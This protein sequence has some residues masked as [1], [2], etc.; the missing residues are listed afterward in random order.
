MT[1]QRAAILLVLAPL[2]LA[3]CGGGGPVALSPAPDAPGADDAGG[4]EVGPMLIRP[5]ATAGFHALPL[6][7]QGECTFV[8]LFGSQIEFMAAQALLDR[9]VF[10]YG[11]ASP[12]IWV[13]NLDGSNRVQLTNNAATERAPSWS[14][15]GTRIAF[16]RQWSGGDWELITMAANGSGIQAVTN[17]DKHDAHPSWSPDGR[18]LVY[19]SNVPGNYEIMRCYE[20]GGS[21]INLTNHPSGDYRPDWSHQA[22]DP[23]ILFRSNRDSGSGE[24]YR[25]EDD[26][27]GVT[28]LT[29]NANFDDH[30]C[31]DAG[32]NSIAWNGTT[33]AG[34]YEILRSSIHAITPLNFTNHPAQ[35]LRPAW[36]TDNRFIAYASGR[37]GNTEIW[38]QE[39]MHPWRAYQ[40]TSRPAISTEPHLG[41]PTMQTERVLI[42]PPGSDWGG[43]DPVWSSAPAGVLVFTNEGYHNFVRIGVSPAYASSIRISTLVS[44]AQSG[45]GLAGVLVEAT[46]IANL[47]EDA[48]RGNEPRVWQFTGLDAG[49]ALLYFDSYTGRLVSALAVDDAT[50]PAAGPAGGL[51]HSIEAGRLTVSGR[52]SA[53][54]DADGHNIAPGGATTVCL[55]PDAVTL[56]ND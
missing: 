17:N 44:P 48:G 33:G 54:F 42:G 4:L 21:P 41:S 46:E 30:P 24:I 35:D 3:G 10:S 5:A 31:W 12:D 2:L 20:D 56:V 38:L 25:M 36:S 47:R 39:T 15:D 11:G 9:I 49:A 14:P 34:A 55:G 50:Y 18:A 13:C 28:R 29:N 16:Q 40:V 6:A 53:V 23:D 8:G 7:S 27:S 45:P 1:R 22:I 37:S 51:T 52:F 32:S 43:L 19:H 26:G